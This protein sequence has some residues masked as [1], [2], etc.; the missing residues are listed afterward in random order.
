M[1]RPEACKSDAVLHASDTQPRSLP[2]TRRTDGIT[3]AG[4]ARYAFT[5]VDFACLSRAKSPMMP[6]MRVRR[7]R[8]AIPR[9]R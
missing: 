7:D 6:N 4:S 5:A 3:L 1:M 2:A 9:T 8:L